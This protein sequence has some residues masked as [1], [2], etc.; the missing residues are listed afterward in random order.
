MNAAS[1]GF[2]VGAW[3]RNIVERRKM[4]ARPLFRLVDVPEDALGRMIGE[5]HP[6]GR[7]LEAPISKRL[8]VYYA[9]EIQ[10]WGGLGNRGMTLVRDEQKG[11]PFTFTDG[12]ET[13]LVETDTAQIS[14]DFDRGFRILGN[15]LDYR[16]HRTLSEWN[17]PVPN[18]DQAYIFREAAITLDAKICIYGAGT[19][20]FV[21]D[22][23]VDGNGVAYRDGAR[24]RL[25]L[26]GSKRY[27]LVITDDPRVI[28]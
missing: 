24:T 27:P 23:D 10:R 17:L 7:V 1:L 26:T 8:C 3:F 19:R 16:N 5:V 28:K 13:A 25:V 6:A 12:S 15:R 2:R 4:L 21:S 22:A 20:D 14:T 9:F 11:A 18:R